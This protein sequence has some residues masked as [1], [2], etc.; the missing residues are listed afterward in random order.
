MLILPVP[1]LLEK[2]IIGVMTFEPRC[3]I[4]RH[5]EP[6]WLILEKDVVRCC[7]GKVAFFVKGTECNA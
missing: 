7:L 3:T 5:S 2:A 6:S 4:V 1:H